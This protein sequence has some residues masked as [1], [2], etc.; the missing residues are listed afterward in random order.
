MLIF[1]LYIKL[2]IL[3]CI[4]VFMS[5]QLKIIRGKCHYIK[6]EFE[7]NEYIISHN[8][9]IFYWRPNLSSIGCDYMV[10]SDVQDIIKNIKE[11]KYRSESVKNDLL[12]HW[13]LVYQLMR[14]ETIEKVLEPE[15]NY[16]TYILAC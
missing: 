4:F 3:F 5:L 10:I 15:V 6:H 8:E 16:N 9:T 14:N 12:K 1:I 2:Q 7:H 13:A 11:K